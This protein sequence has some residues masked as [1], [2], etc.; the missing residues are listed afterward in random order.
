MV[1][2]VSLSTI[3]LIC[4]CLTPGYRQNGIGGLI[5]FGKLT[6]PSP[7]SALPPFTYKLRLYLNA[8]RGE[9]AISGFDWHFTATHNSSETFV[10]VTGSDLQYA[11]TYL[12][13]G[14]G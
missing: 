7:S 3:A 5:G 6:P 9:P 11:L 4:D 1:W 10:S 8:F 2:A 13:P 12:H 14:H